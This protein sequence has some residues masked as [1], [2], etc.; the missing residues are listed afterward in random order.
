MLKKTSLKI[1]SFLVSSR[2]YVTIIMITGV[3][4]GPEILNSCNVYNNTTVT[5]IQSTRYKISYVIFILQFFLQM[6]CHHT[7]ISF[8]GKKNH[9]YTKIMFFLNKKIKKILSWAIEI[10]VNA[11]F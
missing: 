10:R 11:V 3:K 4:S 6:L 2:N 7:L 5:I 1:Y 9:W 8:N